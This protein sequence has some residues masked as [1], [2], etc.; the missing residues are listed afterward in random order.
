MYAFRV[1]HMERMLALMF[2]EDVIMHLYFVNSRII[3]RESAVSHTFLFSFNNL[4]SPFEQ[5]FLGG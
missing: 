1:L 3:D 2:A 4:L 5:I